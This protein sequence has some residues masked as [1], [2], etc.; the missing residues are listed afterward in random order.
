MKK[1]REIL[2]DH[3]HSVEPKL[4]VIRQHL[5]R[6]QQRALESKSSESHSSSA[7]RSLRELLLPFRWHLAGIG[8]AWMLIIFLNSDSSTAA[9][10]AGRDASSPPQL[11]VALREYRRQLAELLDVS[12]NAEPA[13]S[14]P[15]VPKRRG[16]I[17][18]STA[19]A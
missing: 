11:L 5:L 10:Q 6:S 14:R 2:L 15:F 13:Q 7:R 8:A 1:P 12:V 16:E 3:H 17:Q 9:S 4:D 18:S 19:I